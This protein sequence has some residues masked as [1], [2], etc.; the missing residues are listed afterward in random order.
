[1]ACVS[2]GL[3]PM[4][5]VTN[6]SAGNREARAVGMWARGAVR[7]A[8][9]GKSMGLTRLEHDDLR[10]TGH[11]ALERFGIGRD[12]VP[13][14]VVHGITVRGFTNSTAR[15]ASSIPMV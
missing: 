8:S 12:H 13:G 1:M 5:R 15:A 9:S 14:A 6:R 10:A 2:S 7:P 11:L 4:W 3:G